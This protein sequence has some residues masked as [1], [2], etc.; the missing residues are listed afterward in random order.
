MKNYYGTTHYDGEYST[1]TA[2]D[3]FEEAVKYADAHGITTIHEYGG[4]W[5]EYEKCT[6][7]GEWFTSQEINT[8]GLCPRCEIAIRDH[9][10][11]TT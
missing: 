5:D 2:H 6:F 11:P 8:D 10:A 1:L 4:A 7:C 3:T 9:E